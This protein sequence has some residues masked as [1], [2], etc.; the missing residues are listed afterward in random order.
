MMCSVLYWNS[1]VCNQLH[2]AGKV[3]LETCNWKHDLL[4]EVL[5]NC[6]R[7]TRLNFAHGPWRVSD[8]FT[9]WLF[10]DTQDTSQG[11]QHE[12]TNRESGMEERTSERAAAASPNL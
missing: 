3:P 5:E 8:V 12:F 10:F 4:I 7:F 11:K 9:E 1:A 6:V 2:S